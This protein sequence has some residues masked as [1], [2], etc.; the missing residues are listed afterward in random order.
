MSFPVE[1][2]INFL[3]KFNFSV[4][5]YKMRFKC[6]I[7]ACFLL[8]QWLSNSTFYV[9][10]IG[11][12][13]FFLSSISIFTDREAQSPN[14]GSRAFITHNDRIESRS[15]LQSPDSSSWEIN[16]RK[17]PTLIIKHTWYKSDTNPKTLQCYQCGDSFQCKAT[18]PA[19]QKK[20]PFDS[21]LQ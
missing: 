17:K 21:F 3:L 6:N 8:P 20:N 12:F 11:L 16:R 2:L 13:F 14:L 7:V 4:I 19:L 1:L 18:L 15:G 10:L 9:Y 5:N